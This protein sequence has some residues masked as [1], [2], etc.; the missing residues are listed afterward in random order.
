MNESRVESM[1]CRRAFGAWGNG[2]ME[3]MRLT[4]KRYKQVADEK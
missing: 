4:T 3:Y 2:T 1:A